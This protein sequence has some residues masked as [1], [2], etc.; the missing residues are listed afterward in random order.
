[1]VWIVK[2]AYMFIGFVLGNEE[3]YKRFQEWCYTLVFKPTIPNDSGGIKGNCDAELVLQATSDF[4]ENRFDN[5]ILVSSDG[6]FACLV[7]F[8]IKKN[9]FGFL[10]SPRERAK[11]VRLY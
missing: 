4:Y 9:R 1:M 7:K 6:D 8:L 2:I 3:M 10:L 5:A 11:N